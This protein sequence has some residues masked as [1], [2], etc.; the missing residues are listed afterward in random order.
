MD[1]R[2]TNDQQSFAREAI[3]SKRL[4]GEE[5][6]VEEALALWESRERTR[7]HLLAMVDMAEASLAA[8]EGREITPESLKE[9]ANQVKS[10][11]RARLAG[12]PPLP[13]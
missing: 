9:V 13:R 3:A 1:M 12:V 6:V 4:H 10:R 11:G 5:D 2:L 7:A 8:G